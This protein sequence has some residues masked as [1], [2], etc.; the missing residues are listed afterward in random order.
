MAAFF[1]ELR[2]GATDGEYRT[3][4][5]KFLIAD[6]IPYAPQVFSA[7]GEVV[8]FSGR[9]P[10]D[11]ELQDAEVLLVRSITRVDD[12]L[13]DKAAALKFVGTATIGT[14]HIDT[15]A[16]QARDIAFASS[17]GANAESVAEYVLTAL[18]AV[19][20]KYALALTGLTAAIV[21]AGN[22]GSA[23]GRRLQALGLNVVYYDPPRARREASF[24]SAS[25]AQVLQADVISLHVPMEKGTNDPTYHMFGAAEL[26]RLS[27]PQILINASRGAVI[28]NTA[29]RQQL[30]ESASDRVRLVLDVWEG[31]PTIDSGLLALVDI[32]T[33]HIAGHSLNGKVNG[34]RMLY[35]ACAEQFGWGGHQPEWT[36]LMPTPPM[37]NWHCQQMP[38]QTTLT[39][40]LLSNYPIWQDDSLMRRYGH[41]AQGFDQLRR[42]YAVRYELK[43]HRLQCGDGVNEAT[44]QRLQELGFLF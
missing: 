30:Q 29:L 39:Q 36:A 10:A 18:L 5:M 15:D 24:V 12:S 1:Y 33:P 37:V 7:H 40:W 23:T 26:A 32:A 41:N 21:G 28:D 34:T 9:E 22:T 25:F 16:L 20:Q 14:E 4:I 2:C 17:P 19:A 27:A 35:D 13:L 11:D 42:D 6:N 3:V 38:E 44:K 31:E 8:T 43:S